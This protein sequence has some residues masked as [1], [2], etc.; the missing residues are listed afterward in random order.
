MSALD[1]AA[2]TVVA[3]FTPHPQAVAVATQP[4]PVA[5]VATRR[6]RAEGD[7]GTPHLQAEATG[8]AVVAVAAD[9]PADLAAEAVVA[10]TAD[11][12]AGLTAAGT[13]AGK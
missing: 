10:V 3:V 2:D 6:R 4:P 11:P 13:R 12:P 7:A 1:R 5:V 8:E 9:L